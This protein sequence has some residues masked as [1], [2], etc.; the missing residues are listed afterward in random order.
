[1]S[2]FFGQFI[3]SLVLI[4]MSISAQFSLEETKAFKDMSVIDFHEQRSKLAAN[5]ISIR[6]LMNMC[7]KADEEDQNGAS[8]QISISQSVGLKKSMSLMG[9]ALTDKESSDKVS[10]KKDSPEDLVKKDTGEEDD[11]RRGLKKGSNYLEDDDVDEEEDVNTMAPIK[12]QSNGHIPTAARKKPF[13]FDR[14]SKI[15]NVKALRMLNIKYIKAVKEFKDLT[16]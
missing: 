3:I 8:S 16:A 14:Y 13:K 6:A 7:T 5:I 12:A 11:S 10:Q 1:M 15:G 2:M 4:A 9:S